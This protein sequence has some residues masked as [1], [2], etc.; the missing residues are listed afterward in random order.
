VG[1]KG[2]RYAGRRGCGGCV[3]GMGMGADV[4]SLGLKSKKEVADAMI[5]SL[6]E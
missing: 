5:V 2:G 6:L 3:D 4:L 1:S